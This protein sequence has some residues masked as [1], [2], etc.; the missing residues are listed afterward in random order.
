[1]K[2]GIVQTES[3]RAWPRAGGRFARRTNSHEKHRNIRHFCVPPGRELGQLAVA[4]DL[5]TDAAPKPASRQQDGIN[6]ARS[7]LRVFG[8]CTARFT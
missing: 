7:A 5:Q 8:A 4:A 2:N 3:R 6:V 1:M